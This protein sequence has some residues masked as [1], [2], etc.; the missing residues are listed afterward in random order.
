MESRKEIKTRLLKNIK[1]LLRPDVLHKNLDDLVD[2]YIEKSELSKKYTIED[3]PTRDEIKWWFQELP[4]VNAVELEN[5]EYETL[6]ELFVDK[7]CLKDKLAN[8]IYK[9]NYDW[10]WE[11]GKEIPKYIS[12]LLEIY[13][14]YKRC[15]KR[16]KKNKL[17][18][19]LY[20]IATVGVVRF[21]K[22]ER[23]PY[24][25]PTEIEKCGIYVLKCLEMLVDIEKGKIPRKIAKSKLYIFGAFGLDRGSD[26]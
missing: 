7:I 10:Y 13:K 18:T 21:Y 3:L 11:D 24:L 4:D 16:D 26:D 25:C 2:S 15:R 6:F 17:K 14:E 22:L 5:G 9:G 12:D 1:D 19:R 23:R 8:I 20:N